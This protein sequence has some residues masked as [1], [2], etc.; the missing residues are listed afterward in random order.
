MGMMH[1]VSV[2]AIIEAPAQRVYAILADYR[3]GHPRI[4]PQP[5]FHSY[6]LESGGQG[7]GTI[8]RFTM[9]A[10]GK[11]QAFR[12]IVSEPEP[13]RV[14]VE[15]YFDSRTVTTFTVDPVGGDN[16]ARVT[17]ATEL[18]VRGG[19]LGSLER[20][21]ITRFL[22]RTYRREL[23]QLAAVAS[24]SHQTARPTKDAKNE[25]KK[26]PQMDTDKHR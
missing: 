3:D 14:L 11:T 22:R 25:K 1:H 21:L 26:K 10:L 9:T 6:E 13:G 19:F 4:L 8:I 12:G 15:S 2:S 20:F 24:R 5:P 17:F 16:Q 7:A 18:E 23:Q